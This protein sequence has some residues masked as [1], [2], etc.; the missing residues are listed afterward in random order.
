MALTLRCL[1]F[2]AAD[3]HVYTAPQAAKGGNI[4]Y[5]A[6]RRRERAQ[7]PGCAGS[8]RAFLATCVGCGLCVKACRRHVLRISTLPGHAPKPEVDFRLGWCPPECSRCGA[9]CPAG[10]LKPV[11]E[12]AKRKARLGVAKWRAENCLTAKGV[13]CN[14]CLRHCPAQAIRHDEKGRP[15]VDE[16]KCIGCGACEFFCPARPATGMQVEGV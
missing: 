16:A 7:V 5:A 14:A 13:A 10:A 6:P 4:S 3:A 2:G 11:D 1:L 12:A 9:A 8:K 15:V